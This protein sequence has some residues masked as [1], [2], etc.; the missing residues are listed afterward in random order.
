LNSNHIV[1]IFRKKFFTERD[2][3]TQRKR[4]AAEREIVFAEKRVFS[5]MRAFGDMSVCEWSGSVKP[6][7]LSVL[8]LFPSL[9]VLWVYAVP[10]TF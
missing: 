6:V 3:E 1:I 8:R 5:Q 4:R 7:C 2:V 9:Y 10:A